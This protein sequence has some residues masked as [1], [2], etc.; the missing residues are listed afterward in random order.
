MQGSPLQID[1]GIIET[2]IDNL[3]FTFVVNGEG[4]A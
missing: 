2:L 3:Q 4:D 1:L